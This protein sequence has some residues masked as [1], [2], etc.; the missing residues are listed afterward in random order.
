MNNDVHTCNNAPRVRFFAKSNTPAF[1]VFGQ[2]L[3]TPFGHVNQEMYFN[4]LET[5]KAFA[6]NLELAIAQWEQDNTKQAA[7][8][9]AAE[10]EAAANVV[11]D[12]AVAAV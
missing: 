9:A 4:D 10:A 3:T 8:T 11:A 2:S 12:D 7:L 6:N 5:L 1:A